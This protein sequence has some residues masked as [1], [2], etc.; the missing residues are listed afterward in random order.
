MKCNSVKDKLKQYRYM[1]EEV[2]QLESEIEEL[3]EKATSVRSMQF[4]AVPCHT[5]SNSDKIG[6][7]I[8]KLVDM[9]KMY[10]EKIWKIAEEQKRLEEMIDSLPENERL[11]MR[12]KY[13]EGKT[14]E[15]IC[16]ELNY[17]WGHTTRLHGWALKRLQDKEDNKPKVE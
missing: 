13:K 12:K 5:N 3:R 10:I 17:S 4:G 16:V 1:D 7:T 2:R 9:E 6:E 15:Q 14:L 11:L 8:S